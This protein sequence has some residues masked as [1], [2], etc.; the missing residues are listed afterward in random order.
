MLKC[1]TL[2]YT[3]VTLFISA[4]SVTRFDHKT[5]THAYYA[6]TLPY[7]KITKGY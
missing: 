4:I 2:R 5:T 1:Y 3:F 7:W 6:I